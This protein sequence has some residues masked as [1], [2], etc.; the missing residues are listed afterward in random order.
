MLLLAGPYIITIASFHN[1]DGAISPPARFLM[2]L[3]PLL[4]FYLALALQKARS[5]IMNGLFL[6]CA[7]VAM[8]YEGASLSVPGGWMNWEEGYSRPLVLIARAVHL[9]LTMLVPTVMPQQ[10]HVNQNHYNQILP[11]ALWLLLLG[12]LALSVLV[13]SRRRV[14]F[15]GNPQS[16]N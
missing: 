14:V 13:L 5:W 11:V 16:S 6:V 1:W 4:A 3:V 9:P 10:S 12:G 2:V 15:A 7:V 8:L